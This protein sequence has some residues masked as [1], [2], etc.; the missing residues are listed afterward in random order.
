MA[1][2]LGAGE[3]SAIGY[4]AQ[5]QWHVKTGD[6]WRWSAKMRGGGG[7]DGAMLRCSSGRVADTR[8]ARAVAENQPR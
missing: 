5:M 2:G 8:D 1:R 3:E 4:G 7:G 6:G